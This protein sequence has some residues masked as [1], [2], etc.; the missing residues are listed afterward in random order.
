MEPYHKIDTVWRRDPDTRHKTLVE[1]EWAREEFR[2][3]SG[4]RWLWTEKVD[5]TNVRVIWDGRL[6]TFGGRTD[7]AQMPARLFSHLSGHF[8]AE[9]MR[10][11]FPDVEP[12]GPPVC[13]YGEGHGAGIQKGG[14]NYCREQ[15]FA[16]F[17]VRA[18]D[19]WLERENVV[20][21]A[22][23]VGCPCVPVVGTGNLWEAMER[24]RTHEMKSQWGDFL[25]EGLVMRPR[26]ELANRRG[27]RV[28]AKVKHKDFPIEG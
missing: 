26:V 12:G 3:L 10:E 1:G 28:I 6:V 7:A 4:L 23:K 25:A 27:G 9:R 21:V 19:V 11:A 5:G 16:L 17:D 24:V 20:D 22:V 15:R 8:T 2:Y 18:G 14:G 13:L